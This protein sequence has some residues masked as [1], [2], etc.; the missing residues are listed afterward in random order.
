MVLW[1]LSLFLQFLFPSASRM[2]VRVSMKLRTVVQ[3][4]RSTPLHS[5]Q[6]GLAAFSVP[7][8]SFSYSRNVTRFGPPLDA[9]ATR[10][11]IASER[12]A[13][14][15]RYLGLQRARVAGVLPC[16]RVNDRCALRGWHAGKQPHS[17][18]MD[19]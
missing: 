11:L 4:L 9:S 15:K 17:S 6:Y 2:D 12:I 19:E 10:L 3:K 14:L 13:A 1:I 7:H 8:A 5:R 18:V 16:Q